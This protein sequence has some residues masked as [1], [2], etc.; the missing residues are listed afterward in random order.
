MPDP[1]ITK[2]AFL[3]S[4]SLIIA[5]IKNESPVAVSLD[6]WYLISVKGNQRY[7]FPNGITMEYSQIIYITSGPD[8]FSDGINHYM[9]SIQNLWNNSSS[10]P[11]ELYNAR[12]ELIS[13][14]PR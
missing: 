1:P 4:D 9:W 10:D 7:D 8:A 12:G 6:G 2:N 5:S 11:G 13:T 14:W 3:Y